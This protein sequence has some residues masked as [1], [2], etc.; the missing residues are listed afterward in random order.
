[1]TDRIEAAASELR[2]LL[3]EFILWA[4]DNAPDSDPDLVGPVALWHRLTLRDDVRLWRRGDL[5]PILVERMPQVVEDAEAAADGM[6]PAVRAYLPF[7]SESGLAKG[8]EPYDNAKA[9]AVFKTYASAAA[10][11]P[12][13]F[14]DDSKTGGDTTASPKVWSDMAGFKAAFAKFEADSKAAEASVKDLDS[15]KVAFGNM[16]K[17]CGGCHESFR[18][19]K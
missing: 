5:R 18:V 11:M 17:N 4:P 2:P 1:M 14:P 16:G 3:Q 10:K 19:S 13:L 7:L 9:V 8:S 12:S 6:L 15:F